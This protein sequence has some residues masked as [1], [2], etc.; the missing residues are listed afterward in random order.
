MM[1]AKKRTIFARLLPILV[2][3]GL[4]WAVF[5][6]LKFGL[7]AETFWNMELV[8]CVAALALYGL[9]FVPAAWRWHLV[10]Q[11]TGK[12][13]SFGTTLRVSLI[14]HFFYTVLFGVIGGDAAKGIIYA[15]W[16]GFRPEEVVATTPLDRFLGLGGSLVFGGLAFVIAATAGAFDHL[17]SLSLHL[18]AYWIPVAIAIGGLIWVLAWRTGKLSVWRGFWSAFSNSAAAVA[19]SPRTLLQGFACGLLV[20]M[21]LSGVLALNLCAVASGPVPWE[22]ILWT[23]PVIVVVS[24][25]PVTVGGLGTREGIATLLWSAYGIPIAD[26]VAAS[27]LTLSGGLIWA[28]AGGLLLWKGRK[29]ER[30]DCWRAVWTSPLNQEKRLSA[31]SV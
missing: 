26:A 10:L 7:L 29:T 22:K 21:A 28:A 4:L 20:Q 8:W 11:L 19:K 6:G 2:T 5:R 24:A 1:F 18:P 14:G 3:A 25:L 9:L 27:L 23:F 31:K 17:K 30:A 16:R 12:A 13:A 15:R